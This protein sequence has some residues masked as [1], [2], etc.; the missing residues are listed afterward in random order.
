MSPEQ[1]RGAAVDQRADIYAAGAILYSL[2]AGVPPLTAANYNAMIAAILE[3][4]IKPP[5]SVVPAVPRALDQIILRALARRP[6]DRFPD[7]QTFRRALQPFCTEVPHTTQPG[8]GASAPAPRRSPA[9]HPEMEL[10]PSGALLVDVAAKPSAPA[11]AALASTPAPS[12]PRA[13]LAPAPAAL[14][15]TPA[16]SAPRAA[17][18]PTPSAP[19]AASPPVAAPHG[20]LFDT[21]RF[22]A[23]TDG[24]EALELAVAPHTPTA[25]APPAE[26]AGPS[27]SAA[28]TVYRPP[29]RTAASERLRSALLV[30]LLVALAAVVWGYH[31]QI[32]SWVTSSPPP[33]PREDPTVYLLVETE[34]QDAA[35]FVDGVLAVSRPVSL[36][37]SDRTFSVR[38]QS[39]G[40]MSET[41]DVKADR[42]RSI[43]VR[44]RRRGR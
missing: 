25:A 14:A 11:P 18:A 10:A 1:A 4:K 8:L 34:P 9:A 20:A 6:E 28:G 44:L 24:E 7:A 32:L 26:R 35:V 36:P 30:V 2:V 13:A 39:R 42:T 5:S 22:T 21:S 19:P 27:G 23:P 40:Y 37:R 12:A 31:E 41:V 16:P 43:R 17:P 15:S 38:V 33:P 3:A 29:A